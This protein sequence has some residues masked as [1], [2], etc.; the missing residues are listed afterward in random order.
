MLF[1]EGKEE[2]YGRV[3]KMEGG[4]ATI[5][6]VDGTSHSIAEANVSA[7]TMANLRMNAQPNTIEIVENTVAMSLYN[8]FV[9]GRTFMGPE[10][11]SFLVAEILHEYL[12][13][14]Y[15]SSWADMLAA[16]TIKKD[17]DSFMQSDDFTDPLRKLPFVFVIQQ[18]LQKM[19]YKKPF[20]F[21]AMH[22]LLGGYS[23]LAVSNVG[24]RLFFSEKDKEYRYP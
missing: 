2:K 16:P 18:I 5:T 12:L 7:S 9:A 6:A 10:N 22:N 21:G 15:V 17:A 13:K 24:D 23:A 19:I 20:S 1:K 14:G 3:T 11:V 8:K 4:T